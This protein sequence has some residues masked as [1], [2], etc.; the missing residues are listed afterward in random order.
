MPLPSAC[1]LYSK[2][3]YGFLCGAPVLP[4]GC[5]NGDEP[6]PAAWPRNCHCLRIAEN[7]AAAQPQA[8]AFCRVVESVT[9]TQLPFGGGRIR[10]E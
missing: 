9:S 5:S 6:A 8:A 3:C 2:T 7:R 10:G 1:F 4:V